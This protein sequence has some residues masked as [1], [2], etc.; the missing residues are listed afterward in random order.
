M[1]ALLLGNM[2]DGGLPH[3][4]CVCGN[5]TAARRPDFPPHYVTS[6]AVV[7]ERQTPP[8][9]Y[10]LDASPDIKHQLHLLAPWL[11]A[12]PSQPHRLRQPDGI[13]LT[14]GH[15]GHVDGLAQLGKEAMNVQQLPV[16]ASPVLGEL[17]VENGLWR[18]WAHQLVL[19]PLT[20]AK[21]ITLAPDLTITP[22]L[23]PHRDEWGTGTFGF[24]IRGPH[25]SLF[26]VPDIDHWNQWPAAEE[27][28]GRVDVAIVDA[29]FYSTTEL[30]RQI[31]IPHA[32]I[33][34][35]L[36]L[37]QNLPSQLVLTHFNHTNPVLDPTSAARAAVTAAGATIGAVGLRWEL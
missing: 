14:H 22:H 2:Q 37:W 4:G 24:E 1:F 13:F 21:P 9:V 12:H 15:M 23:V 28:L 32:T 18:P 3:A 11:G 34:E 25:R 30:H 33:P 27:I 8:A 35:T 26:Y 10:V 36:Q 19:R 5:C 17:V 31:A 16:Y 6:L 29:T 20:A 7:D